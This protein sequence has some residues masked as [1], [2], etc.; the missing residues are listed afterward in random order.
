ME[1]S[2]EKGGGSSYWNGKVVFALW[3]WKVSVTDSCGH[4]C[5]LLGTP[6]DYKPFDMGDAFYFFLRF[7]PQP[8]FCDSLLCTDFH[9]WIHPLGR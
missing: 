3:P 2:R 5:V 8:P 9:C 6:S 1:G 4:P 7:S